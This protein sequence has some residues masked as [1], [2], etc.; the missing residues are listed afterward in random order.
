[1]KRS[2]MEMMNSAPEV[3]MDTVNYSYMSLQEME[4]L[5]KTSE[6]EVLYVTTKSGKN[7]ITGTVRDLRFGPRG[8]NQRCVNC[9]NNQLGC[10]GHFGLIKTPPFVHPELVTIVTQV[11]NCVC[12]GCGGLLQTKRDLVEGDVLK[13]QG[14][15]RLKQIFELIKDK[16][17]TNPPTCPTGGSNCGNMYFIK[18]VGHPKD[19]HYMYKGY[20]SRSDMADDSR[21][22]AKKDAPSM[23]QIGVN[24]DPKMIESILAKVTPETSELL[25][26]NGRSPSNYVT[27][28]IIVL[29]YAL[30]QDYVVNG[31][32]NEDDFTYIF[33][34]LVGA[35]IAYKQAKAKT[36]PG[37]G[38]AEAK[39]MDLYK[40]YAYLYNNYTEMS[41][42][43]KSSKPL[44][45]YKSVLQGKEAIIR[46][47]IQ[48][49]R[50][51]FA[52]RT[53]AGP[54]AYQ[55]VDEI[56]IPEVDAHL[57]T[58]PITVQEFNYSTM[59]AIFDDHKF[60]YIVPGPGHGN[61]AYRGQLLSKERFI[62]LVS[63][64]ISIGDIIH[65]FMQDGDILLVNRQ[66]SLHK[67]SFAAFYVKLHSDLTIKIN[68]G[69]VDPFNADFDGDELNYHLVQDVDAYAEASYLFATERNY[70][71]DA[72]LKLI[73]GITQNSLTAF[74]IMLKPDQVVS[75]TMKEQEQVKL[76]LQASKDSK[77]R[78]SLQWELKRL[79][80][81]IK[82]VSQ[83]T[84]V[85][86]EIFKEIIKPA[87]VMPDFPTLRQRCQ[88]YGVP[89]GSNRCLVS[90]AFPARLVYVAGGLE[91]REGI[92]IK[93]VPSKK[94]IGASGRTGGNVLLTIASSLGG[95]KMIDTISVA[96]IIANLYL[97]FTGFSVGHDDCVVNNQVMRREIQD[98]LKQSDLRIRQL[99]LSKDVKKM[100]KQQKIQ[101]EKKFIEIM[102]NAATEAGNI[103]NEYYDKDN[104]L[105][106]MA[107]TGAK[108]DA[109]NAAQMNL[110]YGP[111]LVDG[112]LPKQGVYGRTIPAYDPKEPTM[113]ST[114]F[115]ATSFG[116]GLSLLDLFDVN[117]VGR[118]GIMAK[119]VETAKPGDLLHIMMRFIEDAIISTDGRVKYEND[120]T[121]QLVYA[122]NGYNPSRLITADIDGEMV[123][124][125]CNPVAM[126]N[127]IN[128]EYLV[129]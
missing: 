121:V 12:H 29:P 85:A 79:K 94:D 129:A 30:R 49:K 67:F 32:V 127:E 96:Q 68:L 120:M 112:K 37:S 110:M 7:E 60:T 45:S 101:M 17:K 70:I 26:L 83:E 44:K 58:R 31:V 46:Q 88:K 105:I 15:N 8:P 35:V 2:A 20:K 76:K 14:V 107:E 1:M 16:S 104:A 22:K 72:N 93:G 25:G 10:P 71:D 21:K 5:C 106:I 102:G 111:T 124:F 55:R 109:A 113:Q 126:A 28:G 19:G 57:M 48:A 119:F 3:V 41:K 84:R 24:F 18:E 69:A 27:R 123:P 40:R 90:A 125:F 33:D 42:P 13:Y 56:G 103:V 61:N 81:A 108:G 64:V 118:A 100:S 86:P 38:T 47:W 115:C 78:T 11:M 91:I 9:H 122:D 128:N 99:W 62:K 36:G 97:R 63:P 65:R 77:E 114:G 23:A 73:Y 89:W 4:T 66:P 54:G 51:E 98:N 6:G 53:V 87:E 34:E 95:Q 82:K 50:V 74:H 39:R 116:E 80:E 117:R 52:G 92:W 59:N 75:E 43:G